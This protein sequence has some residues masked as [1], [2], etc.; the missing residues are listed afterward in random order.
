MQ[1]TINESFKN[2]IPKLDEAEFKQLEEN[3]LA[4]GLLD[5]IKAT[6]N[7]EVI[8]GHNRFLICQ[9]HNIEPKAEVINFT[10]EDQ[11]RLWIINNQLG[12]RNITD[13]VKIE[14][15]QQKKLI[16]EKQGADN[17]KAHREKSTLSIIDIA[18]PDK[19]FTPHS[20]RSLLAEEL[21]CS[22]G[23]VA[24]AQKILNTVDEPTKQKL[25][26]GDLSINQAYKEIR[27]AEKKKAFDAKVKELKTRLQDLPSIDKKYDAVV[28]DPP[29]DY[30][31]EYD[32]DTRCGVAPY[33]VMSLDQI[34]KISI[35]ATDNAV[36]WL[37]TTQRFL[38]SAFDLLNKWD[39]TY[40][41]TL[42]W[43]KDKLGLG[44]W[45]RH[46]CEFCLLA[47]KGRPLWNNTTYRDYIVEQGREHSRKPEAFYKMV[48]D[49]CYGTKIDYFSRTKRDGCDCYGNETDKFNSVQPSN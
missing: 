7:Y 20:T 2:L 11:A 15:L 42:V 30:G 3:I 8:D 39:F 37:W 22:E 40:K 28:I 23:K 47:I 14:L 21:D 46:Q 32:P 48:D 12:R 10:D 17:L 31:D 29:W 26:D 25:R 35:P 5:P 34:E 33:P 4:Y 36:L 16:L 49:I 18:E 19:D 41:T 9:K 6:Q 38:Y 24:M 43:N 45:L 1:L 13:F 44:T 27:R